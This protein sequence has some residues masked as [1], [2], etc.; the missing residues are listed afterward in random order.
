MLIDT[1]CH[2]NSMVKK[3][4]DIPLHHDD[5]LQAQHIIDEAFTQQVTTIINV[6]T[7][8]IESN[9]CIMLAQWFANNY[10]VIGIHPNDCTSSWRA[11]IQAIEQLLKQKQKLKILGVGECGLDFHYP[12]YNI[13]RQK[14]AFKTQIELALIH[15]LALVIHTRDAAE[16]TLRILDEYKHDIKRGVIHCFSENMDFAKQ[17]MEWNFSLG[18]GGIITY[19]KNNYLREIAQKIDLQHII[20]ETDAPFLPP[21]IMRGKQNSPASIKI[22][23]EYLAQLRGITFEEV[24]QT[25]TANAQRIFN[26][27]P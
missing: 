17:V 2:I 18:L 10:A 3:T 21:Q 13:E 25:T 23:A 9:N 19:P 12:D 1:H 22:I 15:D 4:F 14:D 16:Q 26:L 6:G 5:K 8:L 20:L 27:E 24:A 11:D 7:S